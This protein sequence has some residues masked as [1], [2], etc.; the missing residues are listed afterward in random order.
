M[1]SSLRQRIL[2]A[3][4]QVFGEEGFHRG[5]IDEIAR[6]SGCSRVAFYQYFAG[7]DD[8]F[9]HLAFAVARQVS[10]STET[11]DP[12]TPDRAGWSALRDVGRPL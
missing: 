11:L 1:G 7:K 2:D 4:L 3:A 8:L 10:A 9:R 12:L 6:R 5:S